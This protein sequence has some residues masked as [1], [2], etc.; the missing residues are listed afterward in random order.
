MTSAHQPILASSPTLTRPISAFAVAG[1]LVSVL[2]LIGLAFPF[3]FIALYQ[4]NRR[5]HGGGE[6]AIAGLTISGWWI[7]PFVAIAIAFI[8]V[9]LTRPADRPS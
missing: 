4:I 5:S 8:A 6:L 9:Y 1:L 2:G 3:A 7:D